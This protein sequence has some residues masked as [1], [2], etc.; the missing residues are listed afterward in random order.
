M[1][2]MYSS[3]RNAS[4][5]YTASKAILQG[6]APDG[7]LFVPSFIPKFDKTLDELMNLNYQDTAYEVMKLLLSDFTE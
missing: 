4:E 5:K 3:T 2:V 1:D 6:L 7:G